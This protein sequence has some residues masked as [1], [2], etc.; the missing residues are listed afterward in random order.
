M[1][2]DYPAAHSMDTCF[3]VVDRDGHVACFNTLQA[4]AAPG[5][6]LSEQ[7]T[8][9]VREQLMALP[10]S[11]IIHDWQGRFMPGQTNEARE[12][13]PQDLEWK[14][15]LMFLTSL[16]GVQE[17]IDAGRA[18]SCPA[19]T[20]VAVFFPNLPTELAQRLHDSGACLS[21]LAY[22]GNATNAEARFALAARGCF[23]YEHLTENWISGP[24][25]RQCYPAEPLH[26][27]QLPPSLRAAVGALR[28]DSLCFAQAS[29]VQPV[30][31]AEC[32]SWQSAYLDATGRHI[33][34]IPGKEKDYA[35]DYEDLARFAASKNMTVEPPAGRAP[36]GKTS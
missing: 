25:G 9:S 12:H 29:H 35:A 31:H 11:G 24:Y 2:P 30:E 17:E 10:E 15:I 28:F 5:K 27:D 8:G 21:C 1:Q 6:S 20:G 22:F 4:G 32:V 16:D 3:F 34:P 26:V 14:K 19:S 7:E 36:D 33:R 13:Y 18:I 23:M